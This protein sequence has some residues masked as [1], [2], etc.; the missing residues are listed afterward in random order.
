LLYY[1]RE[2][3]HALYQQFITTSIHKYIVIV[4]C[5]YYK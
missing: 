1:E 2:V 4:V 5:W 3:T